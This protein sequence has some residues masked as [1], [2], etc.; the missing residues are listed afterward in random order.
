VAK[1]KW[2]D[3]DKYAKKQNMRLDQIV[4]RSLLDVS[5][6]VI[7][8]TAVGNPEGWESGKAPEGYV[9]GRAR[10]NWQAS[11]NNIP[12]G[13]VDSPSASGA[14]SMASASSAVKNATGQIYYLVNNLPY[15]RK[16]EYLGHS[17]QSPNGMVRLSI[18]EF[19]QIARAAV[20][21]TR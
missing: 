17:K 2:S 1:F 12:S 14:D 16:L 13:E 15:I 18:K 6:S 19:D 10:N 5:R 11:I 4:R 7:L 20:N 21:S 9:G 3:L 8:K